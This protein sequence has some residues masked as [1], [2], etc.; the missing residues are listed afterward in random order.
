MVPIHRIRGQF[1]VVLTFGSQS[2]TF[3]VVGVIPKHL[4]EYETANGQKPL[5]EWLSDLD[6]TV[7]ARIRMRIKRLAVGNYGDVQPV[8]EGVSELRIF[9]GAG[10]R[11]YFGQYGEGIVILLCGG[12][13]SSQTKDIETAKNYWTDFKRRSNG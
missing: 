4:I 5:E 12:D 2:A 6:R 3:R 10:Y 7:S 11:V 8:G 9:F 13:K 1:S